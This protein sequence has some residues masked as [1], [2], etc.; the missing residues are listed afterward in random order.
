M[1]AVPK[2]I[3]EPPS[4]HDAAIAIYDEIWQRSSEV[5]L[6]E[7]AVINDHHG[8]GIK[9]GPYM[10]RQH[11]AALD[12]MRQIKAALDPHDVMNPGKLGL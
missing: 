5:I 12:A 7:G 4:K 2:E 11:G 3:S 8:V 6:R 10:R 1:P 9:L